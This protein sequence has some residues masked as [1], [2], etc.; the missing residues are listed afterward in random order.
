MSRCIPANPVCSSTS[1]AQVAAIGISKTVNIPGEPVC[2][3][4]AS[5]ADQTATPD[6]SN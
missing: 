3:T 2:R 6:P 4:V 1:T 5:G